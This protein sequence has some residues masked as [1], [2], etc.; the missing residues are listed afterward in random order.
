M[1]C[2]DKKNKMPPTLWGAFCLHRR[3]PTLPHSLPCSTIGAEGLNCRVRDGNGCFP[4]AII[5]DN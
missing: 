3:R 4:F 1:D 5:A 2:R